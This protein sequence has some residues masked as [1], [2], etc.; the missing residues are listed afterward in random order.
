MLIILGERLSIAYQQAQMDKGIFSMDVVSVGDL[1]AGALIPGALL[2]F[3]Y[4]LYQIV[5]AIL[6]P[7]SS[8]A[9]EEEKGT[10]YGQLLAA[11]LPAL[12]MILGVL[13][14]I[15]AGIATP[16]EAASIGCIGAVLLAGHKLSTTRSERLLILVAAAAGALLLFL[17]AFFDLRIGRS[18]MS[19]EYKALLVFSALPCLLILAGVASGL[20]TIWRSATLGP[21]VT[22][23][24]ETTAMIFL[25][26]MAATV[27][28]LVFKE[29]G[30]ADRIASWLSVLPGGTYGGI[31]IVMAVIFFLGFFLDFIEIVVVVV[32]LVA[33]V[34]LQLE[35]PD[36]SPVSP[37]WLGILL[38]LNLQT[39]F[40]TPP[41]GVALF[42]LGG[43]APPELKTTDMYLG[44]IPFIVIQLLVIAAV[45]AWPAMATWLPHVMYR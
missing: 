21:M 35:M 11:V 16:T 15:L 12:L 19:A 34:L 4:L 7:D 5:A 44:V 24:L 40:L 38:G 18:G 20:V 31:L 9:V 6:F 23:T 25:I 37:V 43:V 8:P 13:G 32:P 10:S 45:M 17:V 29:L 2:V 3:G 36:G 30:G 26:M 27:F 1:F 14:S 33:P 28:S 22:E 42:Y 41:F 39:S